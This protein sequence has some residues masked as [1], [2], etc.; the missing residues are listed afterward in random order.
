MCMLCDQV[1][2]QSFRM[3]KPN[4]RLA[5]YGLSIAPAELLD[6]GSVGVTRR[7]TATDGVLDYYLHYLKMIGLV[8]DLGLAMNCISRMM[9]CS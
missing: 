1:T 5:L 6:N 8:C 3:L 4:D 7:S 9:I 2:G